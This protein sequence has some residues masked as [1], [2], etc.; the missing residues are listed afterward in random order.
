MQMKNPKGGTFI[1]MDAKG[2]TK[3][4]LKTGSRLNFSEGWRWT[5]RHT[6]AFYFCK[7]ELRL[8]LQSIFYAFTR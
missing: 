7:P 2:G 3:N 4:V 6:S 8:C 1:H 5:P